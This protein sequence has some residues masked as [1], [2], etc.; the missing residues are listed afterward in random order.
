MRGSI[1]ITGGI[2]G[3]SFANVGV[4]DNR[5]LQRYDPK[6]GKDR[7]CVL[8]RCEVTGLETIPVFV[9]EDGVNYS[10]AYAAAV[11]KA[12]NN[13]RAA[14]WRTVYDTRYTPYTYRATEHG[15]RRPTG[16][17][18]GVKP[19]GS[20]EDT[21]EPVMTDSYGNTQPVSLISGSLKGFVE[22]HPGGTPR[23]VDLCPAVWLCPSAKAEM[24][25]TRAE[26]A[27]SRKPFGG[28]KTA[29]VTAPFAAAKEANA[30]AASIRRGPRVVSRRADR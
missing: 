27:L 20:Y 16:M 22:I 26:E 23:K 14:G 24:L 30:Q 6:L 4:T 17:D 29:E 28:V 8:I 18:Q 19:P 9:E 15:P 1:V 10:E 3:R 7:D 2:I 12:V 21:S 13:A 25:G 11:T 5:C